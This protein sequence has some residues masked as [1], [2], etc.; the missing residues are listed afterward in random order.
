MR[1]ASGRKT[2][3]KRWLFALQKATFH[4]AK[5]H[6]P[7]NGKA[8]FAK[9]PAKAAKAAKYRQNKRFSHIA[10]RM[11]EKFCK[12]APIFIHI[13]APEDKTNKTR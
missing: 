2:A 4:V 5:R 8:P 11:S 12:F 9:R 7:Q 10:G 13:N 1:Y 6:L 3:C